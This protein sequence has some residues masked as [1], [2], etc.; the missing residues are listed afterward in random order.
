MVM[1][2]IVRCFSVT[3]KHGQTSNVIWLSTTWLL[4]FWLEVANKKPLFTKPA[5]WQELKF[6]VKKISFFTVTKI[7]TPPQAA[8]QGK[9]CLLMRQKSLETLYTSTWHSLN[10]LQIT[11]VGTRKGMDVIWA[12]A[13]YNIFV[14]ALIYA[15]CL[16][17]HL[18]ER[19]KSFIRIP[20]LIL[21]L[22]L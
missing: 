10:Y 21:H 13:V 12:L 9:Y 8:I 1:W 15:V 20:T 22:K 2:L 16:Y 3:A 7:C 19:K 18:C 6:P 14:Y 5:I 17:M 4:I 11:K